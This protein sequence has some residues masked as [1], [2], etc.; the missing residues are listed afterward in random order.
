MLRPTNSVLMRPGSMSTVWIPKGVSSQ[1][2]A[3]DS[4]S[5]A[6][7]PASVRPGWSSNVLIR[8]LG[9]VLFARRI[10]SS[11]LAQRRMHR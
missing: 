2:M 7:L 6:Y 3:S 1:R 11:N 9:L 5:T 10:V 4:D 8:G